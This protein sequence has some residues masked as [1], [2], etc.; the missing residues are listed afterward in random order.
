VHTTRED[1]PGGA[2][3]AEW[4]VRPDATGRLLLHGVE[5]H[6]HRNGRK[7]WEATWSDGV[8][9]GV[10]THWD[11]AGRVVWS[12]DHRP[13][14]TSVW[15]QYRADGTKRRESTWRG[16]RCHGPARAWDRAGRLEA[17]HTFKD[18]VMIHQ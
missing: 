3:K 4:G 1:H 7:E 2:R 16:M 10:E 6:W 17:E 8:K 14:G 12:W 9:T 13:D 18:G 5:T 11:E 15:T